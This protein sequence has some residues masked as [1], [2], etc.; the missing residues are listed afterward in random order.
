MQNVFVTE[1]VVNQEGNVQQ[2]TA[3]HPMYKEVI[4]ME[5]ILSKFV[6]AKPDD[7]A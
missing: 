6:T 1:Q 3:I 5:K 7:G 4:E 2:V